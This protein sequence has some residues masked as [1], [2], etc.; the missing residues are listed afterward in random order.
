MTRLER[1]L[2][3]IFDPE[4]RPRNPLEWSDHER[5]PDVMT[6]RQA[7][8]EYGADADCAAAAMFG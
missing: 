6:D 7:D 2:A 1:V 3:A 5:E 4:P 8:R